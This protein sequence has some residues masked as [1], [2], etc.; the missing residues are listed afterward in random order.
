[1]KKGNHDQI[2]GIVM[3][4][5]SRGQYY[6]INKARNHVHIEN[7]DCLKKDSVCRKIIH[8][9]ARRYTERGYR[10][11]ENKLRLDNDAECTAWYSLR[12]FLN[13]NVVIPF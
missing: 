1:M 2:Y 11:I 13:D 3:Y 7:P 10:M 12:T 9:T 5:N 6:H 8:D 4:R